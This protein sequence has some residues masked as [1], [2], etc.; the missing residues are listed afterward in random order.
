MVL[1]RWNVMIVKSAMPRY[2]TRVTSYPTPPRHRIRRWRTPPEAQMSTSAKEG[3]RRH[4]E[5]LDASTALP[6]QL[7]I[8]TCAEYAGSHLT[9]PRHPDSTF[10]AA[11]V[12]GPPR[13]RTYTTPR[14]SLLARAIAGSVG[15]NYVSLAQS[16]PTR[17]RRAR[18]RTRGPGEQKLPGTYCLFPK[19]HHV[20]HGA[21]AGAGAGYMVKDPG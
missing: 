6:A 10:I 19:E 3:R 15:W 21:G 9:F 20:Y 14:C 7:G 8:K 4:R 17:H 2:V 11:S 18:R 12:S 1:C 13:R 5:P 16:V